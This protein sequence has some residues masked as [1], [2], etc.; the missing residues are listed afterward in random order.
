MASVCL[1]SLN[2]CA[3]GA[4]FYF[5]RTQ[6]GDSVAQAL[7]GQGCPIHNTFGVAQRFHQSKSIDLTTGYKR[8]TLFIQ[9]IGL[10][11]N[12][13]MASLEENGVLKSHIVSQS[14]NGE[15]VID[16]SLF[17]NISPTAYSTGL[18]RTDGS[19]P[20]RILTLDVAAEE[21]C[22]AGVIFCHSAGNNSI[23]AWES[24]SSTD[25]NFDPNND[26]WYSEHYNN[27]YAFD[28]DITASNREVY[29]H[30][31][32]HIYY[33]RGTSPCNLS[34]IQVG[35]VG[36]SGFYGTESFYCDP[37]SVKGP[38]VDIY[39]VASV[40]NAAGHQSLHK[41]YRPA[42]LWNAPPGV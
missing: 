23:P 28:R 14:F 37:Y 18:L 39:A 30:A 38:R 17:P 1:G 25:P 21:M 19:H 20:L 35:A 34:S 22:D 24:G 26:G 40:V 5:M 12:T 42:Y 41:P 10:T 11:A 4:A 33:N 7:S 36:S 29:I 8:P 13:Q 3:K 9:S 32:E 27:F 16:D 6:L 15:L 2:G 31:H